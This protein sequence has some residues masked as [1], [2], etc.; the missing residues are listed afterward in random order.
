MPGGVVLGQDFAFARLPDLVGDPYPDGVPACPVCLEE[1]PDARFCSG[2]GSRLAGRPAEVRKMV[3]VVF[4]DI[5]GSTDLAERLDP[6]ALRD[7][8]TQYFR[9]MR[10]ALER[11]GGLLEKYIGDAIMGIFGVPRMHE[12]DALR[13]V[14]A[15]TEMREVLH[16]LNRGLRHSHGVTIQ[17]R[18]GVNT[19]E[20][21]QGDIAT[22]QTLAVGH[23]VSIAARLEQAAD[24]GEILIGK[25][26]FDLT[27]RAIRTGSVEPL[28]LRGRRQPVVA[29]RLLSLA[30]RPQVA[31]RAGTV[32]VGRREEL[33]TLREAFAS[34]ATRRRCERVTIIGSAGVG[35][36]RLVHEFIARLG[37]AAT[38]V[39]GRCL[40]YGDAI[41]YWPFREIVRDVLGTLETDPPEVVRNRLAD[42]LK[43]ADHEQLATLLGQLLGLETPTAGRDELAWAV[44][45]FLE[46][47]A[48]NHPT[49]V[50]LD[51]L[52]WA[53]PPM[54]Q[55]VCDIH[56]RSSGFPLLF[57]CL[58]RPDFDRDSTLLAAARPGSTMVLE[59]LAKSQAHQLMENIL[60]GRAFPEVVRRRVV[61]AAEGNPLFVE[62]LLDMLID[63]GRLERSAG[64]W[65]LVGE[66]DRLEAPPT[67]RALLAARLDLIEDDQRAVIGPAALVGRVFHREAVAALVDDSARAHLDELLDVLVGKDLIRQDPPEH[68]QLYRFRHPLIR[69]AAYEAMSKRRR[70]ELHERF[71]GWLRAATGDRETEYDGIVAHHLEQA[72]RYRAELGARGAGG[73]V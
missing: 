19:G 21:L 35:K 67:I 69:D 17:A 56:L 72:R 3:T 4:T 6:E 43:P 30:D 41:T 16:E 26:T 2:C 52:Q 71:A 7:V 46:L 9:R 27:R 51:D 54:L 63:A 31:G 13:A 68:E 55:L 36:S 42:F 1:N 20:V 44:R 32:L 58:F 70:A 22:G 25:T 8:L 65:K 34:A 18:T 47:V 10:A 29:Y 59:P 49:V 60:G 11:H 12:D 40:P 50:V 38:V 48:G 28:M 5:V 45:R 62:Q 24:P 64:A 57:L 33:A 14:R 61:E 15:A 53:D 73:G 23:P 37:P 39:R 66:L